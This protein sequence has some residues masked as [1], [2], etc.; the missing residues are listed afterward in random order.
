M[1]REGYGL[2][3][4]SYDNAETLKEFTDRH[5]ITFPLLSDPGSK[6]ITAWGI[7]N[8]EATGRTAGIPHPG[9][10]IVDPDGAIVSRAFEQ[11]Y[12]ERRSATS[13]LEQLSGT[14][15]GMPTTVRG[16]HVA[17]ALQAS[18]KVAAVGHRITLTATV[19]PDGK[20]HVYAPGQKGY[21]PISLKLTDDPAFKA[22]EV[23]FPPASTYLFEPLNETVQVYSA[24]FTLAMDV[25]V[26]L[27][28]EM[29]AR[30]AKGEV[31]TIKGD[32]EYQAC[33]DKVC[34]RPETLP[35]EWKVTLSPIVAR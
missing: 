19:T 2:V 12:T 23:K 35:V 22:H 18:D 9:T 33:D 34:H 11:P 4:I 26:A 28:P 14:S 24:P 29:R 31:L 21:I 32:L 3:A 6:T 27:T 1:T 17:L 15:P 7:L 16:A 13:I 25:T 30:A 5:S 10:F 8:K 20:N